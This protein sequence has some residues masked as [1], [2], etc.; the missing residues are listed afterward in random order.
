MENWVR[1]LE[2]DWY[3]FPHLKEKR[4]KKTPLALERWW[5]TSYCLFLNLHLA[6]PTHTI[7]VEGGRGTV[8]HGNMDGGLSYFEL[9]GVRWSIDGP[10]GITQI[11][12]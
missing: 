5:E 2:Q 7:L 8:N 10:T 3:G 12:S 6:I 4:T 11:Y 1:M 9:N